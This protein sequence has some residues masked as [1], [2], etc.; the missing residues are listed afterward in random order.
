VLVIVDDFTRECLALLADSSLSSH[1][2]VRE[3]DTIIRQRGPPHMVVSDRRGSGNDP[4]DRFPEEGH[5][6][7]ITGYPALAG[8]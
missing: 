1:R 2:V 7:D 8:R 6:A 5:R 4:V 3:L